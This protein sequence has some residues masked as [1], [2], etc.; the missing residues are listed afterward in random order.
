MNA[1][2]LGKAFLDKWAVHG[3]DPRFRKANREAQ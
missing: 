1:T 2:S 3:S